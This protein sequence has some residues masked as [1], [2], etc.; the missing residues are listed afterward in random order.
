MSMTK[1]RTIVLE[2][3]IIEILY[4]ENLKKKPYLLR[5]INYNNELY[6]MRADENDLREL[7]TIINDIF[8][9]KYQDEI[10]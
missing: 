9:E 7:T 4:N 10:D 3:D 8:L 6:E 5:F 2:R 1:I